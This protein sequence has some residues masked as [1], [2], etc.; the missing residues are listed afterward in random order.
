MEHFP[1]S[2]TVHI[3]PILRFF[4]KT[5]F[6]VDLLNITDNIGTVS[7]MVSLTN[8]VGIL[9]DLTVLHF[10]DTFDYLFWCNFLER[11]ALFFLGYRG[12]IIIW[13]YATFR[14]ECIGLSF[15]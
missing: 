2:D 14:F 10:R 11:K 4:E 15:S 6:L 13:I 5:P 9:P 8:M 3:F 7:L 1:L 12:Q